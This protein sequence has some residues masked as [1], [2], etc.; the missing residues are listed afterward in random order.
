MGSR[1]RADGRVS[2]CCD[3]AAEIIGFPGRFAG[4]AS[5]GVMRIHSQIRLQLVGAGW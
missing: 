4:L 3:K 5:R 2:L 1:D